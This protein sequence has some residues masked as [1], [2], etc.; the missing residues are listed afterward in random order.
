MFSLSD[1]LV[2]VGRRHRRQRGLQLAAWIS[3]SLT[4]VLSV[5]VPAYLFASTTQRL[6]VSLWMLPVVAAL[7]VF[8]VA[9][10]RRI[11]ISRI[12]LHID[13]Q[14][15]TGER[16]SS[17]YEVSSRDG[18]DVFRYRIEKALRGKPLPWRRAMPLHRSTVAALCA[19]VLLWGGLG[20]VVT[21]LWKVGADDTEISG[22]LATDDGARGRESSAVAE[23]RIRDDQQSPERSTVA[24]DGAVDGGS[25][26][27]EAILGA[28]THIDVDGELLAALAMLEAFVTSEVVGG[29]ASGAGF[30]QDPG[31][32]EQAIAR[33][34][35]LLESA[36]SELSSGGAISQASRDEMI[37]LAASLAGAIE[38]NTLAALAE[39]PT[40]IGELVSGLATEEDIPADEQ[41][42]ISRSGGPEDPAADQ[43]QDQNQDESQLGTSV[44]GP[45]TEDS[46]SDSA[47]LDAAAGA[48]ERPLVS[49]LGS[50]GFVTEK[51]GGVLTDET[52]F[53]E[54]LTQGIPVEPIY[55][56]GGGA[57][58]SLELD[59]LRLQA[60]VEQ[61]S[62]SMKQQDLI[63]AYFRAVTQGGT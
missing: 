11:D 32:R 45:S 46:V 55:E 63:E 24:P 36:Q 60:V 17:L 48:I 53:R 61:R 19:A 5:L 3:L 16:L 47:G 33:A 31:R 38:E 51:L 9:G 22:A 56:P 21:G 43:D 35:S 28:S 54:L 7:V 39:T 6:L 18:P 12:L 2:Q 44:G 15:G 62:L 25:N 40:G 42:G 14:L 29:D 49:A 10:R 37:A 27:R 4:F 58:N 52:T 8:A 1:L 26:L 34:E 41:Q 13:Q 59:P 23:E 30:G 57:V 20:T 50:P